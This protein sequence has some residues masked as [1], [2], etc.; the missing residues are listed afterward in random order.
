[1]SN[2]L[3][4]RNWLLFGLG[5]GIYG[6]ITIFVRTDRNVG[7]SLAGIALGL[8]ASTVGGIVTILSNKGGKS[9][10]SDVARRPRVLTFLGL[11]LLVVGGIVRAASGPPALYLLLG[12][13]SIVL[14]I[15]AADQQKRRH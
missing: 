3:I 12:G 14:F 5:L 8:A 9:D 6:A 10:S 13:L 11:A 15:G 7:R 2:G 1:M 4:M